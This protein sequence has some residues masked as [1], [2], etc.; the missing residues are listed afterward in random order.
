MHV[1]Q[2]RVGVVVEVLAEHERL[3][4]RGQRV[5]GPAGERPCLEPGVAL[6]GPSLGEEVLLQRREGHGERAAV[7]VRAQAHV[8]AEDVRRR[9]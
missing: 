1:A 4:D 2:A 6:P 5:V 7:A 3:D 8:D 9:R